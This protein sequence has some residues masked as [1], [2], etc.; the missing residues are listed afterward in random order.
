MREELP[1]F[2]QRKR[3]DLCREA[4]NAGISLNHL[5]RGLRRMEE[6]GKAVLLKLTIAINRQQINE[7]SSLVLYDN[8]IQAYEEPGTLDENIPFNKFCE[9]AAEA[10]RNADMPLGVMLDTRKAV[11]TIDPRIL[12]LMESFIQLCS[13][14]SLT[15]CDVEDR[16]LDVYIDQEEHG[17]TMSRLALDH[18]RAMTASM[19]RSRSQTPY[20]PP[21]YPPVGSG[22]G[23]SPN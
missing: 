14:F 7:I 13:Q 3:L 10:A 2:V 4:S 9:S 21:P 12:V 5:V 20:L 11:A 17:D 22:M 18:N 15:V 16:L 23:T 19:L 1:D 6:Y 8:L